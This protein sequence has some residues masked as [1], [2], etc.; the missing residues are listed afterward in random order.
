MEGIAFSIQCFGWY[1]HEVEQLIHELLIAHFGIPGIFEG[2][3][4]A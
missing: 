3:V 4:I 2:A 1:G